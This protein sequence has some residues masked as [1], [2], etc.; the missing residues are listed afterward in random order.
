MRRGE[1]A[2]TSA[3]AACLA[4]SPFLPRSGGPEHLDDVSRAAGSR[5]QT[6]R[7][8]RSYSEV[9]QEEEP[10]FVQT[11]PE[12]DEYHFL[13]VFG[14]IRRPK[15]KPPGQVRAG[16]GDHRHFL[17]RFWFIFDLVEAFLKVPNADLLAAGDGRLDPF[18]VRDDEEPPLGRPVQCSVVHN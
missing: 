13:E 2:R 1:V 12:G 14:P 11:S 6:R 18:T 4:G 17:G 9:V 15:R 3:G 7:S 5:G 16:S 8:A 10:R